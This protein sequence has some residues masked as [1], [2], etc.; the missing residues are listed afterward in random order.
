MENLSKLNKGNPNW[1][2][3]QSANPLGRPKKIKC[4]PDILARIG[5]MIAPEDIQEKMRKRYRSKDKIT[6]Q[7]AVLMMTYDL[8]AKGTEWAVEFIAERTEGKAVQSM[9]ITTPSGPLIQIIRPPLEMTKV[10]EIKETPKEL[11]AS[12]PD[13]TTKPPRP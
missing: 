12:P 1:I 5:K 8:A 2:K 10:I 3:G 7:Q 6:M 9:N 13:Q 11:P 4:I